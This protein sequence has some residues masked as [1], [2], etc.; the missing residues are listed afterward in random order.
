MTSEPEE[1]TVITASYQTEGIG[2]HNKSWISMPGK[3]LLTSIILYPN[4]IKASNA[5]ILNMVAT[6]ALVELLAE[7]KLEVKIKWPNDILIN[8]AKISGVLIHNQIS[9]DRIKGTVLSIGLNVNKSP[10]N[11]DYPVTSICNELGKELEVKQIQNMLLT[12]IS[13]W[14]ELTR[15]DFDGL[16]GA[17]LDNLHGRHES[18]SFIRDDGKTLDGT[19]LD[20]N[21]NGELIILSNDNHKINLGSDYSILMP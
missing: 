2:R 6:L 8:G 9:N 11:L 17:F 7:L 12:G 16:K 20:V 18:I 5:Y 14:Y 15:K 1:G 13:H 3:N 4:H 21:Y 10:I 19:I